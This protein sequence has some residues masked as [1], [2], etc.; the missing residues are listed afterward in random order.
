MGLNFDFIT[1]DL[2]GAFSKLSSVAMPALLH[3]Q[4]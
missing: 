1:K 3:L 2:S 4:F